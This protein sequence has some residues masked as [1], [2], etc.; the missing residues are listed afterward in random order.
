[1]VKA[2]DVVRTQHHTLQGS[3]AEN[4]EVDKAKLKNNIDFSEYPHM[5]RISHEQALPDK[6]QMLGS[7][8]V[9][10]RFC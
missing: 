9:E 4:A 8:L 1:M 2:L 5:S 3:K 10:P 6:G 7:L